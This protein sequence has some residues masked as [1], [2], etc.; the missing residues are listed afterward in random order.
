MLARSDQLARVVHCGQLGG[1]WVHGQATSAT[2]SRA[3]K[4]QEITPRA[5]ISTSRDVS[6]SSKAPPPSRRQHARDHR[7][8]GR[9]RSDAGGRRA[10]GRRVRAQRRR[11]HRAAGIAARRRSAAAPPRSTP[12]TA[13][14]SGAIQSDELRTPVGWSEIPATLKNA[15]VAIEDQRF[16]K[17]NGVDVTGIFRAA[18]KDLAHGQALQGGLDDHD[19][20]G[21]Q[22]L[23][24]R[25]RAHAAGRRSSRR[26]SR[27]NTTK[28]HSKQS[29]L[30]SYL[31]SVPYGTVGGQTMI[32]V[33]A[34][35]RIFFN[36][37]VSQLD[38]E[39]SALLA[40]LP[41][42]PS[43]YNPFLYPAVAKQRRNEVLAKMAEL[44]YISHGAGAGDGA[45]RRWKSHRGYYYSRT[46][47]G[48]LL[49]IRPPA[50]DRP[51]RRE[52]GRTG[53]PEGVHDDRPQHAAPGAQSDRRNPRRARKTRPR[54]SSRSTRT[55][56]TSRRW[57]SPRATSSRSTTSPPTATASPARRSRRSTSPTRSRAGIDPYT[58]LLLLAHAASRLAAAEPEL[59]SE[60]VRGHLAEQVDQPRPRRR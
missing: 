2:D 37:P 15:T 23:P 46:Q 10:R 39:Q 40:G 26:S 28:H 24:G 57:P 36:K 18:V 50:A 45:R 5:V 7:G 29:I 13:R 22:P 6:T 59:Q 33:Q 52:D 30:N 38:L 27:S 9:D 48:L 3:C 20:A 56:A 42:A 31:N 54:R 47:R 25:R 17:D 43:Q 34:A 58:H 60:D 55:T 53:R 19:A 41:Q 14:V 51:L 4:R 12:P 21:A 11:R 16:Y 1:V 35:A 32:G 8:R 44:H 49:R